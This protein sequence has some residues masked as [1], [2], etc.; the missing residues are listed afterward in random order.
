MA[1]RELARDDDLA[2]RA[3]GVSLKDVF[4]QIETNPRDRR[5]FSARLA[6]G[7][8]PFS[9]VHPITDIPGVHLGH[10]K[11]KGWEHHLTVPTTGRSWPRQPALS[12][13]SV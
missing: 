10:L 5:Q 7:R 13:L 4:R 1:K 6:H 9:A 2:L 11:T 3:D 12:I 8:L